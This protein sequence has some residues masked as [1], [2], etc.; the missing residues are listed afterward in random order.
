MRKPPDYYDE[1]VGR[2]CGRLTVLEIKRKYG[3]DTLAVCRCDCGNIFDARLYNI[4]SGNT[5]SCGCVRKD[6][7]SETGK[8]YK[9][10]ADSISETLCWDCVC[11]ANECP[12]MR[13]FTPVK[14]W[15]AVRY[16]YPKRNSYGGLSFVD[17]YVVKKC[18]L[19]IGKNGGE[20][21]D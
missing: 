6:T 11:A 3:K 15:V 1:M 9:F 12:W 10:P 20:K 16:D 21:N 17:S 4:L 8:K 19:F 18:P 5:K 13:N 7:A 14:G 2:R